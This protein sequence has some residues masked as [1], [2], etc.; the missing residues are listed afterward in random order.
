MTYK[1]LCATDL[2]SMSKI[3]ISYNFLDIE[4]NKSFY[5]NLKKYALEEQVRLLKCP[6]W[7]SIDR[8]MVLQSF[9]ENLKI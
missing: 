5:R 8:D 6:F 4:K 1:I 2:K 9:I 3:R 7:T